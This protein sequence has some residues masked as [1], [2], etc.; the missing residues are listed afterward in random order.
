M[1]NSFNLSVL[2]SLLIDHV[3]ATLGVCLHWYNRTMKH[4]SS[5]FFKVENVMQTV[6]TLETFFSKSAF[7]SSKEVSYSCREKKKEGTIRSA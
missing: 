5:T 1:K 6:P 2:H 4:T 3:I 7:I